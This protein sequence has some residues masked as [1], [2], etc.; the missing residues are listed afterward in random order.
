MD[1]RFLNV[2]LVF[3]DKSACL[4]IMS[5]LDS[6][7]ESRSL[8]DSPSLVVRIYVACLAIR[9]GFYFDPVSP[10]GCGGDASGLRITLH[11]LGNFLSPLH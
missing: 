9:E 7:T 6:H 3:L 11:P 4:Q 1:L 8:A 10:L 2:W 5:D